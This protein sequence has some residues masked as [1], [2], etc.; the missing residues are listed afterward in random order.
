MRSIINLLGF[1]PIVLIMFAPLFSPALA[2]EPSAVANITDPV[3][4][5]RVVANFTGAQ[6]GEIGGARV[7]A[8]RRLRLAR[9]AE[10][11]LAMAWAVA[12]HRAGR[13]PHGERLAH[14]YRDTPATSGG[15]TPAR[16]KTR[17]PGDRSGARTRILCATER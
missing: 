8:D 15:S 4:I 2:A 17:R 14:L 3:E 6:I 9:C 7:P 5:D 16:G 10:P 12:K 13:M 1:A 11:L